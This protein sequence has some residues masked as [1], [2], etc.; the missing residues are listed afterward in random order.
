MV[1]GGCGLLVDLVLPNPLERCALGHAVGGGGVEGG[2]AVVGIVDRGEVAS[3]GDGDRVG[4]ERVEEI[5]GPG[6]DLEAAAHPVFCVVELAG[7]GGEIGV[8]LLDQ[9]LAQRRFLQRR[10][11]FAEQVLMERNRH[12]RGGRLDADPG[13]DG[14]PAEGLRREEAAVTGVDVVAVTVGVEE[15]LLEQAEAG[16][17]VCQ[18]L[19]PL[20]VDGGAELEA[21]GVDEVQRHEQDSRRPG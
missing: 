6:H 20:R 3:R 7:G 14:A 4:V 12:R 13:W 21:R 17:A 18:V 16:H 15:D 8:P 10:E 2:G 11:C 9:V 1:A 19:N 5:V